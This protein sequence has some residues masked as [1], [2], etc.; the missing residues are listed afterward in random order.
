MTV[1]HLWFLYALCLASCMNSIT[2]YDGGLPPFSGKL[3]SHAVT[4]ALAYKKFVFG[5]DI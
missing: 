2:Q 3:I 5:W 4:P 1:F